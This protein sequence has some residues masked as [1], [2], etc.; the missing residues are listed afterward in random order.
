MTNAMPLIPERLEKNLIGVL[1]IL[2]R[3]GSGKPFPG[4]VK[5]HPGGKR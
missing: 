3:M 2:L 1:T 4:I 5:T